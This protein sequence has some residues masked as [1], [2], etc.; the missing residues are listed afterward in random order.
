MSNTEESDCG[1]SDEGN[2][3]RDP[4]GDNTNGDP[5]VSPLAP[6]DDPAFFRNLV[7]NS[8]E[9]MLTI[10]EESTIIF[11][12]PAIEDVLGYPP[13][14]L[15]GNSKL[16]L[17]P[18]RL[19]D[20]HAAG[21]EAYLRTG[22]KHINWDGI[23]L[24]ALHKDGHEVPVLISL[25]EHDE[26]GDKR[27]FTGL[28]RDLSGRKKRERQ[29]EAVFNNT[30]QFTGLTDADGVLLEANE[31]ALSFGNL[32]RAA[33]V[34]KPLWEAFWFQSNDRAQEAAREAVEQA[35]TGAF[36]RE[37]IRVQGA[38]RTAIIDFSV[39]PVTDHNGEIQFLIPEGRNITDLKLREQHLQVIHRLLRH[40]LRNEL[41][42]IKGFATT[43]ESEL[44]TET[45][46]E[47]ATEIDSTASRLLEAS[48]TA[49]RL[50]SV[51]L[52]TTHRQAETHLGPILE[53]VVDRFSTQA[54]I[55]TPTTDTDDLTVLAGDRLETALA[56]LVE[57][58]IEHTVDYPVITLEVYD[59]GTDIAVHVLDSGPGIP[60]TEQTGVFNDDSVTQLDHGSGLGLWLV[61]LLLD[62]YGGS[63]EYQP[64]DGE[65]SRVIVT[66]PTGES[67]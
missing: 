48:E 10:D 54:T 43:L 59:Y 49:K 21:L 31:T 27:L 17:I 16:E 57:N 40:N 64:R 52:D 56:E 5:L 63:F 55:T 22:D 13:D 62:D 35:Q 36:F 61:A 41:N 6:H 65:G 33:V 66:L 25:R 37:E 20:A 11:A 19:R 30:Y 38:E 15:I 12:N 14:E 53:R 2:R 46:R 51:T 26:T 1:G 44:G 32:E 18:P 7:A 34:G 3:D 39:R 24:P 4:D 50:A 8:S 58:A 9:G 23:E 67:A 29:F 60:V 42:V 45:H 28:F 47:Y